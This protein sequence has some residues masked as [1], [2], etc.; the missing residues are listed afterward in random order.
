MIQKNIINPKLKE[1]ATDTCTWRKCRCC[2]DESAAKTFFTTKGTK[3]T[4]KFFKVGW[5]SS[6]FCALDA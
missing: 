5:K 2:T 6:N 4:K 1:S 3:Y